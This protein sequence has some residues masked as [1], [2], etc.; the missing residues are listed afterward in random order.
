MVFEGVG[1]R[2][3]DCPVVEDFNLTLPPEGTLCLFGPSGCG[4]TT[5]LH[6]LAGIHAPDAG[7]I[8]GLEGR[9]VSAVFQEPRLLPWLSA[10]HNVSA[11]LPIPQEGRDGRERTAREWLERV[12]LAADAD[13]L[14]DE[15]S[16]GMRQRVAIARALAYGG[17]LLLLDEPTQGLDAALRASMIRLFRETGGHRLTLLV[18]HDPDEAEAMGSTVLTLSGPPVRVVV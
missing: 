18:T 17:D 4:K 5:L 12:G 10:L 6:L 1:K 11:V 2:F 7:R 13:K 8:T 9:I 16:G 3:G 15:L 14:P